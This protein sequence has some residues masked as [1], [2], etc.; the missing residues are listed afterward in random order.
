MMVDE[1]PLG[2]AQLLRFP[3]S[4]VLRIRAIASASN[5][6]ASD[7]RVETLEGQF[8]VLLVDA[9]DDGETTDTTR[10]FSIRG[11][12]PNPLLVLGGPRAYTVADDGHIRE[13]LDLERSCEFAEYW[14]TQLVDLGSAILVILES[15]VLLIDDDLHLKWRHPKL[16]NDFFEKLDGGIA[17]FRRDHTDRWDLSLADGRAIGH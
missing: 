14:S 3:S 9:V 11:K 10:I 7:L 6:M 1:L 13:Q 12:P 4:T 8:L 5:A 17:I 16:F 2:G 15:E